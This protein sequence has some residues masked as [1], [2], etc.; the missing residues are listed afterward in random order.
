M[1]NDF[2]DTERG[3]DYIQVCRFHA[4][5]PNPQERFVTKSQPACER[6]SVLLKRVHAVIQE[7]FVTKRLGEL[8]ELDGALLLLV[9]VHQMLTFAVSLC[10]M[11]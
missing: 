10:V 9:R 3:K 6:K 11:V 7:R 2:F 8:H 1:N 4:M 5:Q